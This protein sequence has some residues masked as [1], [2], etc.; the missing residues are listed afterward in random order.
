MQ[1]AEYFITLKRI[2]EVAKTKCLTAPGRGSG[3]GS[4]VNY[5]LYITDQERI[6]FKEHY[7]KCSY[8]FNYEFNYS[9]F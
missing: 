7:N 8:K 5:V 2:M 4:L 6:I 3:A 1:F 9:W